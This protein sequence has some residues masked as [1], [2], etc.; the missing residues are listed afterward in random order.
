MLEAKARIARF[1]SKACI[2]DRRHGYDTKQASKMP[3]PAAVECWRQVRAG[4]LGHPAALHNS[5]LR[6]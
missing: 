2:E 1:V 6:P 3:Q 5:A 4:A